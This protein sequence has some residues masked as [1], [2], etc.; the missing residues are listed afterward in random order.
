[1]ICWGL[2]T[3][4][5]LKVAGMKSFFFKARELRLRWAL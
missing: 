5:G 3:T 4:G 1:M 2:I